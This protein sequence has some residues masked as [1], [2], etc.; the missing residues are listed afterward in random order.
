MDRTHFH[1]IL[2]F[3]WTSLM[4]CGITSQ[5]CGDDTYSIYQMMLKGH[6]FKSLKVRPGSSDCRQACFKDIRCHSYNVII[7]KSICE[8]NNR[9]KEAKPEDFIKDKDRYYMQKGSERVPLGF[10]P[11]LPADSCK[12]IKGSEGRQVASDNYWLRSGKPV[13]ARCNMT[14]E[15]ADFCIKHCCKNNPTCVNRKLNYICGCNTLRWS[16]RYC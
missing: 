5:Q 7:S 6:T 10:I 3:C 9:T 14:T 1:F 12:E 11:E 16:G 15:V 8:L 4:I 13:I 2:V